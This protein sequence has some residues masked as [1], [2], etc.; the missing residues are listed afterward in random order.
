VY[1]I[2]LFRLNLQPIQAP[3][4]KTNPKHKQK[5]L[6]EDSTAKFKS[7]MKAPNKIPSVPTPPS[8]GNKK[9]K[10]RVAIER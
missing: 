8:F 2:V 10:L 3:N 4:Q 1:N 6:L 7:T 5:N 9:S